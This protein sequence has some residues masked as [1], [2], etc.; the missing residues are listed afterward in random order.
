MK[1]IIVCFSL[2]AAAMAAQ[3]AVRMYPTSD[4]KAREVVLRDGIPNVL[5]KAAAGKPLTVA[6]LG[7]S[8]TEMDGWRQGT[9]K[10]LQALAPKS[11]VTEV[12]AGI[13]G[14][15]SSLGVYRAGHDA[16][17]HDPD[18]LF[19]E[20]ATNDG[21][22]GG[23]GTLRAMEGIVRQ[24]RRHDP[25]TDVVFVYTITESATNSYLN[26]VCTKAAAAHEK[27]AERYGVPSVNFGPRVAERLRA[28]TLRIRGAA[29]GEPTPVVLDAAKGDAAA[30]CVVFANDGTHPNRE[31]HDI[32]LE[33]VAA[34]LDAA[35]KAGGRDA[36]HPL[37]APLRADN[38]ENAKIV[39][40]ARGMMSG[41]WKEVV[42]DEPRYYMRP[43]GGR[44]WETGT[45]GAKVTFA[46]RGRGGLFL[47]DLVGPDGG[48]ARVRLDGK[49]VH[50]R[51]IPRF[52]AYA[53][54]RRINPMPLGQCP[55]D[56]KAHVV[57]IE[58]DAQEPSRDAVAESKTK[59][60]KYRGTRMWA[61][62]ILID[63][64]VVPAPKRIDLAPAADGTFPAQ[65]LFRQVRGIWAQEPA[66]DVEV[67]LADGAYRIPSV[68]YM[69]KNN[70][71]LGPHTGRLVFRAAH[72]GKAVLTGGVP[73]PELVR[74]TGLE[75]VNF[76]ENPVRGDPRRHILMAD[77]KAAG[78]TDYGDP[79]RGMRLVW[80]GELQTL[81][82][83]PNDRWSHIADPVGVVPGAKE[84]KW[85]HPDP[86]GSWVRFG[87]EKCLVPG[88]TRP[89]RWLKEKDP[90]GI[91]FFT[92]G[93]AAHS[94][95]FGKIDPATC[96]I[97][98]S[99]KVEPRGTFCGYF[100]SCGREHPWYAFN[101]LC[102]LDKPGEY[103]I[104][105]EKG[106]LYFWPP[107]VRDRSPGACELTVA[108]GAFC[109]QNAGPLTL[110]GL[111]LENFRG[112]A[113]AIM[114][115]DVSILSC[116]IR[117]V[118]MKG[119]DLANT[120]RSR[121]AGC[122]VYNTGGLGLVV[123]TT[124]AGRLVAHDHDVVVEN[125]HFHDFGQE[126]LSYSPGVW[127]WG[128]GI[129]IRDN[130]INGGPHVAIGNGGRETKV[131]GNDVFDVLRFANE[132]GAYYCGRDW[133]TF[134]NLVANN[135]FHD[136]V[137][138]DKTQLARAIMID[139]G[140]A[141]YTIVSNVFSNIEGGGVC[142][143]SVGNV[144]ADNVFENVSP[145]PLD[146]WGGDNALVMDATWTPAIHPEVAPRM[147][148]QAL[149]EEPWKSRYPLAWKLRECLRG[150]AKKP[151]EAR[152]R[153]ENNAWWHD[154]GEQK[155]FIT[156]KGKSVVTNES[157]WIIRGNV[158]EKR[159]LPARRYGCHPSPERFSWPL[160]PAKKVPGYTLS[161]ED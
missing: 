113:L 83:W 98:Q 160:K 44:M 135:W 15:G 23:D 102:E 60:E 28:G 124:D 146:C 154:G 128:Q 43:F 158:N 133:T 112:T 147:E 59:P 73:L 118:G 126:E 30:K 17:V 6:Y 136:L 137:L 32:Y 3:G 100:H 111:V 10:L 70:D 108:G 51:C 130:T 61:A 149:D 103:Y 27:V 95:Q 65:A 55:D 72:R 11:R 9:T 155:P 119:I 141:G 62:G 157:A 84:M 159:P 131:I 18:L 121:V 88:E 20:F 142:L 145:T 89:F 16:L 29:P 7:G 63:G 151:P 40:L 24:A 76:L 58:L 77:L 47:Y 106:V 22:E 150:K 115:T 129:V 54:Y 123:S 41:D 57:E 99:E 26:G 64:D 139:D 34:F 13:G 33:S 110:D 67:V 56:G 38:L 91:G 74:A 125:N 138:T 97:W 53:S 50:G 114:G 81:A 144:V 1:K 109:W 2:V 82:R 127:V 48:Q 152:T 87:L 46:V 5:A 101:V 94:F 68:V 49:D 120:E 92:S 42:G 96:T 105:R 161:S 148:A 107:S 39:P 93:W 75:D 80:N 8:I 25:K 45:P 36:A 132:M 21:W 90:C 35:K 69:N 66:A 116:E 37:P 52:D 31:G 79:L 86:T 19:V 71:T 140:G 122:D 134:G 104:D 14:T 117:N 143:S 85:H 12:N 156:W 153:I 78:I 4:V